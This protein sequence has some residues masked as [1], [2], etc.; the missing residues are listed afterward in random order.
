MKTNFIYVFLVLLF[1]SCSSEGSEGTNSGSQ[2]PGGN[3]GSGGNTSGW[4]IPISEVKDGGPGKDGIPSIDSPKFINP[5][6]VTFLDDNDLVIG[7]EKNGIA[8]AYPHVVLDWHEVVNDEFEGESITINYCPL[9]GTAFGWKS[10][11]NG[12][13]STFGVS[14]LLYNAN[15][16]LYDRNTDSNWSQLRLECVNGSLI[17]DTPD[18]VHVIETTWNTW[19]TLYPNTKVLST[20]TGFSRNYD[21]YPYG[22]YKTAHS[23]FLFQPSIINNALQNKVRVHAIID[24]DKSK[25]FQFTNFTGGKTIK[26]EFNGINYLIVG[27]ENLIFSYKLT[28][29]QEN[30]DFEY[31]FNSSQGVFFKDN[32]GNKW[33]VFGEALEGPRAGETLSPSR[34][35]ISYW[36]AIAVFYPNPEIY[37]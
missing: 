24:K 34:S 37:S 10:Q 2:L 23:Y 12:G 31:D 8:R 1:T 28:G 33:S 20:E 35:V 16:I 14:G 5:N 30:L 36:F 17:G 11:S 7:I 29:G 26:D 22:P 25:V 15:L 32:E 19:K 6:E 18:L 4:L 9:T 27:N 13:K 21:Q 3:N